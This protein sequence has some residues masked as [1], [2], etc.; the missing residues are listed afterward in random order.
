MTT[1]LLCDANDTI[2]TG[3]WSTQTTYQ[4]VLDRI[5]EFPHLQH[6]NIGHHTNLQFYNFDTLIEKCQSLKSFSVRLYPITCQVQ[7]ENTLHG[8]VSKRPDI[9]KLVCNWETVKSDDQ[10]NYIMHKLPNLQYLNILY[11]PNLDKSFNRETQPISSNTI[12]EFF[13]YILAIPIVE[14]GL[15]LEK[16]GLINIYA[17]FMKT[18]QKFKRLTRSYMANYR[19]SSKIIMKFKINVPTLGFG[20]NSND[21]TLSH[22]E[23][24]STSGHLTQSLTVESIWETLGMLSNLSDMYYILSCQNW[25][26]NILEACPYLQEL[27]F[28][29][30]LFMLS[31][32]DLSVQ[33]MCLN[34]FG[35]SIFEP[36]MSLEFLQSL[37]YNLPNLKQLHFGYGEWFGTEDI[38]C[39]KINMP[40]THFDLITCSDIVLENKVQYYIGLQ[41]QTQQS[42]FLVEQNE[43]IYISERCFNNAKKQLSFHIICL[44]LIEFRVLWGDEDYNTRRSTHRWLF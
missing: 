28:C 35:F 11:D 18:N 8:F 41:T 2:T 22:F 31:S 30:P 14:F 20:I 4:L 19:D 1:L 21:S 6:L 12:R 40:Y 43:L 38:Y 33:P 15:Q 36:S 37:S 24:L 13:K 9:N 26:K 3:Q 7:K 34:S 17:D 10:L 44:Q 29:N 23:F 32:Y 42:F 5:K 16:S 27:I 39:I 25:I